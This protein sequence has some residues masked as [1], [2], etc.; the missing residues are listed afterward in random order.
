MAWEPNRFASRRLAYHGV[1]IKIMTSIIKK[2]PLEKLYTISVQT[3]TALNIC[4]VK[5]DNIKFIVEGDTSHV[6]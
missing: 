1:T 2:I 5:E 3:G 4:E 6:I